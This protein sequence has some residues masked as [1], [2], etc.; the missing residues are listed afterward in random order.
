[1]GIIL[2]SAVCL[3]GVLL[4]PTFA[5]FLGST[6]VILVLGVYDDK[7]GASRYVRLS[8]QTVSCLINILW[9]GTRLSTLGTLPSGQE[10]A[11]GNLSVLVTIV[12]ILGMINAM[13][14]LHGIDGL[15]ACLFLSIIA[16]LV[17]SSFYLKNLFR[18]NI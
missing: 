15:A 17:F 18:R 1:M 7:F 14:M 2:V 4:N 13:N 6:L 11:I 8:I 16:Q 3:S 10:L 9:A 12:A 5:P